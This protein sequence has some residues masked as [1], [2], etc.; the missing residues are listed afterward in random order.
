M[1]HTTSIAIR[2]ADIDKFGHVN[3]AIYL[4]YFE[5]ARIAYLADVLGTVDWINKGVILARAEINFIQPVLLNDKIFVE[6][7]CS[8]IG[9]KSFDLSYKLN[10]LSDGIRTEMANGLTVMV[11]FDYVRQQTI[12]IPEEW[13]QKMS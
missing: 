6:T 3:N 2:F 4:T 5:S 11:G 1:S 12:V 7:S 10:K 8:R 9:N 13:K